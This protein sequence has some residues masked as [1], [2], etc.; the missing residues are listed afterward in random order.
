MISVSIDERDTDWKKAV[1]EEGMQWHQLCDQK[2]RK[3]PVVIE[4]QVFG[5][6]DC[7]VLD[8]EGRSYTERGKGAELDVVV[9]DLLEKSERIVGVEKLIA[10]KKRCLCF[11]AGTV[12]FIKGFPF[13]YL[14]F[15]GP[16]GIG[17]LR[18]L[19]FIPVHPVFGRSSHDDEPKMA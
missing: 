4:Y 3:G 18:A 17:W 6:P 8:P 9:Q 13:L 16:L 2:G 5:I 7:I 11:T 19:G 12:L 14:Y 1:Q 10:G 15:I